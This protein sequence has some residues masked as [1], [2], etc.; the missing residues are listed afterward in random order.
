MHKAAFFLGDKWYLGLAQ[1]ATAV[2]LTIA[3]V[4]SITDR[5]AAMGY[6]W[7]SN[8][9]SNNPMA[10]QALNQ[11]IVFWILYIISIAGIITS[12]FFDYRKIAKK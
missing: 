12:G 8:L 4:Q 1:L 6:V 5:S 10:I 9:E 2:F 7:F 3:L 11:S